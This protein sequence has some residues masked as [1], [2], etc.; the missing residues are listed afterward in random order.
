MIVSHEHRFVYVSIPW[1][2][3]SS[4][5]AWLRDHFGGEDQGELH[6]E[7]G[8]PRSLKDYFVFT[9][10]RSP[11]ERCISGWRRHLHRVKDGWPADFPSFCERVG[12]LEEKFPRFWSL[13]QP[14]M[15]FIRPIEPYLDRALD[16]E[17]IP[18]CLLDLPFG[19]SP[20]QVRDFPHLAQNTERDE[21]EEVSDMDLNRLKAW[22]WNDFDHWEGMIG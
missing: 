6:M 1:T 2:A 3:S 15:N 8:I 11:L 18:K 20:E 21:P 4:T 13:G 16:F 22:Y 7:E 9:T 10:M 5:R 19:P 12:E 17:K 14:Q